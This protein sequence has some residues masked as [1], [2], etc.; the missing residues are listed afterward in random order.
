MKIMFRTEVGGLEVEI[1]DQARLDAE[2]KYLGGRVLQVYD[3]CLVMEFPTA[4]AAREF[5]SIAESEG[6]VVDLDIPEEAE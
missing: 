5:M 1:K 3:K 6:A 4:Q 2:F